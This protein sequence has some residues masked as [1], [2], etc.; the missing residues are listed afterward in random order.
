MRLEHHIWIADRTTDIVE[1]L[2]GIS[3]YKR[4]VRLGSITPDL[5]PLR[6]MQLHNEKVVVDHFMKEYSRV[7]DQERGMARVSFTLGLL[8]HYIADAFC[9]AH[10]IYTIDI[11]NHIQYEHYLNAQKDTTKMYTDGSMLVQ[12]QVDLLQKGM[13]VGEYIQQYNA[14]YRN[15]VQNMPWQ[16]IIHIDSQQAVLHSAALLTHFVLELQSME[17]PSVCMA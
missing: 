14:A 10:N 15:T 3:F 5:Q 12:E 8:C 11:K 1:Q 7:V 2:V 16:E 9:L 13:T 6:R 17:V 4:L